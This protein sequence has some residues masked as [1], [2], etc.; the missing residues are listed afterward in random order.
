MI[1]GCEVKRLGDLPF[2]FIYGT[3]GTFTIN[4]DP[5]VLLCFSWGF[6]NK[7]VS[8]KR[9]NDV[10]LASID[11]FEFDDEFDLDTIEIPDSKYDHDDTKMANYQGFPL[12]LGGWDNV[13]LE[14]LATIELPMHWK[15]GPN[16][17]YGDS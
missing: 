12:I 17:P 13:A 7:C 6:N 1:S 5:I 15:Q 3:C 2:G 4:D 8:L 10:P 11:N 16:Y 9:K 14:M